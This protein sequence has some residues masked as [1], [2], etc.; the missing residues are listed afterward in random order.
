MR[1]EAAGAAGDDALSAACGGQVEA[2]DAAI[3]AALADGLNGVAV[4]RM[5]LMHLQKMHQARLRMETGM[6][7]SDAVR[8]MRPPVFFKAVAGMVSALSLWSAEGLLRAIEEARQVELACKQTGS[9]PE[10]LARRYVGLAGAAGS[11]S[12]AAGREVRSGLCPRHRRL[13]RWRSGGEPRWGQSA[14]D[15]FC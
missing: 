14:P 8:A 2:A 3:E 6:A 5:A 4:M 15:P 1:G 10:L 11:R 12:A 7:A 9:R 13:N